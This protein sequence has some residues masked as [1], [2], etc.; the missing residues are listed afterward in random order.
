MKQ[1]LALVLLLVASNAWAQQP[2][3]AAR[4]QI[5]AAVQALGGQAYCAARTIVSKGRIAAFFQGQPTGALTPVVV[6][7]R[8]PDREHIALGPKGSVVQIFH[9]GAAWEITYKGVKPLPA[10]TIAAYDRSRQY[11]LR[12]V[13]CEWAA[14]P[15]SI[16]IDQGPRT[17]DGHLAHAVTVINR[18]NLSAAIIIDAVTHL[19]L[20][21]AYRWR[22][23]EFHDQ[24]TDA[25]IYANYHEVAGIA[26]PFT[27]TRLHNGQTV[28]QFFMDRVRYNVPLGP[29]LF[30]PAENKRP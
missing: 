23:P 19:P 18:S 6:S 2:P 30:D 29:G 5:T 8:L 9:S 28:S 3:A 24:N 26:T 27:I 16:L 4:Q 25:V 13:L 10:T 22:D 14:D 20:Q 21:A 15:K 17:A 1:S 12:A 11:A 7:S